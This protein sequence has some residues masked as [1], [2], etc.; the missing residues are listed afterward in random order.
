MNRG[1][2]R[3]VV[4]NYKMYEEPSDRGWRT[5]QCELGFKRGGMERERDPVGG[6]VE[7]VLEDVKKN[8]IERGWE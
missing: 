3:A 2:S 6:C 1:G 4:G 7:S 5:E 8:K